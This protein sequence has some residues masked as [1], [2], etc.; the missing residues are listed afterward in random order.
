MALKRKKKAT[1][2]E[3]EAPKPFVELT[4]DEKKAAVIESHKG[5]EQRVAEERD[6]LRERILKLSKF[7]KEEKTAGVK[8]RL[9][10]QRLGRQLDIMRNYLSILN[11]R[12]GANFE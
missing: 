1:S 10:S 5:F 11:E 6:Q 8:S 12:I 9:E 2:S 7:L 3:A 4:E